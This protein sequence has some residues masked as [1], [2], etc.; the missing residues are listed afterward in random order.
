[1]VQP[2]VDRD[3]RQPR[4]LHETASW[5]ILDKPAGWHSVAGRGGASPLSHRERAGVRASSDEEAPSQSGQSPDIESWLRER[6]GWAT[7]LPEAGLV[8]RLDFDTTG[9]LL[10]AKS[11]PEQLRLRDLFQ[12]GTSVGKVYLALARS[13][14][15][16]TGEFRLFFTSRYKRSKKVTVR[17]EGESRHEGCCTWRVLRPAPGIAPGHDLVEIHLRGAGRR[18]QIRA[19]LARLGHP[20]LGDELY[21]GTRSAMGLALHAWKLV[22]DGVEV[23][24]PSARFPT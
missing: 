1:M 10:V 14:L 19:G 8:H 21:G 15:A 18:H 11:E 12:T 20:L 9:C 23:E 22:I 4:L 2:L 24:S 3:H 13:G 16:R 5:L 6:F 7:C 17:E